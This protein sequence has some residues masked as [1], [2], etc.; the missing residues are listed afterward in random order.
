MLSLIKANE[1]AIHEGQLTR[2]YISFPLQE[3]VDIGFY[4]SLRSAR[5]GFNSGMDT[6]TSLKLRGIYSKRGKGK[7][8]RRSGSAFT[9]A[10]IEIINALS[11][12]TM[13]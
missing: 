8:Y 6:L 1:Q 5:T 4:K 11:A 12:S 3:L 7:L 10:K 13:L 9:G 2:D